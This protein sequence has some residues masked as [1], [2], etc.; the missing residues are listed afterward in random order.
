MSSKSSLASLQSTGRMLRGR[1]TPAVG[2]YEETQFKIDLPLARLMG[3]DMSQLNQAII[4]VGD[5][6][7]L[8]GE[9]SIDLFV[10]HN[11]QNKPMEYVELFQT[12]GFF[13]GGVMRM[14]HTR[15]CMDFDGDIDV[16]SKHSYL[17]V[18]LS[19][20]AMAGLRF[21]DIDAPRLPLLVLTLN[22]KKT[23]FIRQEG[24]V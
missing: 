7:L 18:E 1:L 4:R 2:Q 19:D 23:S 24:D 11:S 13:D 17:T 22:Y 15:Y 9:N 10:A 12:P 14:T 20:I 6:S 16:E 5:M 3:V 8:P 21:I